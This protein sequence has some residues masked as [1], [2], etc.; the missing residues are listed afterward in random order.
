MQVASVPNMS[1]VSEILLDYQALRDFSGWKNFFGNDHP[2][3]VE[4]GCG[5]DDSLIKRA[6]LEPEINFI[7][8]END[9]G[10]AYRFERKVRRS[11]I[12]NLRIV[13]FDAHFVLKNLLDR[14]SVRVFFLQFPDPWPKRRHA[15]RRVL[16][17]EFVQ[18]I[19][20]RLVPQGEFFIATDVLE[21]AQWALELIGENRGFL[22]CAGEKMFESQKPF[23]IFT[24]YE[25]KFMDQGL[26]IYYLR[27]KKQ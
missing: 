15:R 14:E 1:C 22:N 9:A 25:Q 3:K 21:M 8:I 7:G 24:L 16:S 27:F 23:S 11:K 17:L 5:K 12:T 10:I 26:P 2:L 19:W 20:E 6:T 18:E 13:L 4:I